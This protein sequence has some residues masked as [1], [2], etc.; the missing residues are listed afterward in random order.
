M[1]TRLGPLLLAPRLDPKPWGGRALAGF[2]IVLPAEQA[3]SEPIGEALLTA[4]EAVVTAG[5]HAGRTLGELA[6]A[7]PEALVGPRGHAVTGGRAVF[8]LL[9]KLIDA[10]A[11]LSVQVHP[12]DEAARLHGAV[13]KTEAWHVLA[14]EPGSLLYLGLTSGTT[15]EDL[16]AA[17]RAGHGGGLL[18]RVGAEPGMTV[19]LPAGTTH[20]MG[21]GVLVYEIQQPS[22]ITYRLDDWGRLDATGRSRELHLEAGLAV[23]RPELRPAPIGPLT[24]PSE[25]ERHGKRRLLAA[26]RA[27]ALDEVA[28]EMGQACAL[29]A[30]GSPQAVTVLDGQAT[31]TVAGKRVALGR[32]ET[33]VAPVGETMMLVESETG[34]RCF[35]GWVPDLLREVIQPAR[36]A[37]HSDAAIAALSGPLDD[38]A[39]LLAAHPPAGAGE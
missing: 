9:I 10:A 27:F 28:L 25:G 21:A 33:A 37:G 2:G 32:G 12:G 16:E 14:A 8:P 31:L 11:N 29:S 24:L 39:K 22:E 26:C 34:T 1:H 36:A 18:E 38:L 35:R 3:T 19:L 5:P 4:G 20:A 13:G 7:Y 6:A 30:T 15:V 23:V 17:A